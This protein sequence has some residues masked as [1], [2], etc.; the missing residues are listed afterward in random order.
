[1]ITTY[2]NII[3]NDSSIFSQ[4]ILLNSVHWT[5]NS[6]YIPVC[7]HGWISPKLTRRSV[8]SWVG[9]DLCSWLLS[10]SPVCVKL[11]GSDR[12]A[13]F[14][15]LSPSQNMRGG[16]FP[17]SKLLLLFSSCCIAP[18]L[19]NLLGDFKQPDE[20]K[21]TFRHRRTHTPDTNYTCTHASTSSLVCMTMLVWILK[22]YYILFMYM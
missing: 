16:F 13:F 8:V 3:I 19:L 2:E 1:M 18:F 22:Y 12:L 11:S 14:G 4:L 17:S 9:S 5:F 20:T 7:R 6:H 15:A 10:V 21:N